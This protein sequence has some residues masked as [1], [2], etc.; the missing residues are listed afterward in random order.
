MIKRLP[1][2]N[3]ITVGFMFC[4]L[5][6][7]HFSYFAKP[8]SLALAPYSRVQRYLNP[9]DQIDFKAVVLNDPV[10]AGVRWTLSPEGCGT[11][12]GQSTSGVSFVAPA[13]ALH[14][15]CTATI[16]ETSVTD[17]TKS[18]ST[19][20][21]VPSIQIALTPDRAQEVHE[22]SV[23]EIKAATLNDISN[24]GV[25]WSLYTK[26]CGKL[27]KTTVAGA[28]YSAPVSQREN[29]TANITATS[30]TNASKSNVLTVTVIPKH[31]AGLLSLEDSPMVRGPH[32]MTR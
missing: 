10:N 16:S 22:G 4:M 24:S 9:G 31:P 1:F 21:V 11:L 14:D 19:T 8:I 7:S 18:L 32:R 12:V 29:C 30:I 17:A 6:C 23:I 15:S 5:G 2:L 28:V 26:G 3:F 20:V 13:T 27:S 25:T